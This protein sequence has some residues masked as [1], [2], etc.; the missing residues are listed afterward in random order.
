[1][2]KSVVWLAASEYLNVAARTGLFLPGVGCSSMEAQ[3]RKLRTLHRF[4]LKTRET[5]CDMVIHN[6]EHASQGTDTEATY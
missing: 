2:Y 6:S 5:L 3:L 1:M 4:W